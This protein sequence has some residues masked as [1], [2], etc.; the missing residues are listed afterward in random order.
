[1]KS[2]IYLGLTTRNGKEVDRKLAIA[3]FAEYF[4]AFTVIDATGYWEGQE[5]KTLVFSVVLDHIS[6]LPE[7]VA[8]IL[9]ETFDQNAVLVEYSNPQTVLVN[10]HA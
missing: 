5:E 9:A 4:D 8:K 7:R 2:T 1:M 6:A 3:L 10:T